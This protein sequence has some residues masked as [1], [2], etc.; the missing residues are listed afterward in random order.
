M[1]NFLKYTLATIVGILVLNILGLIIFFI[2]A[3]AISSPDVPIVKDHSVL[4]SKFNTPVID[5]ADENP[6][7]QF[8]SGNF[9][10]D[11][12]MGLDQILKDIK[13]AKTD[14]KISGI[15]LRLSAFP[16]SLGTLE[17]IRDA[18]VDFKDSGKFILAHADAYSMKTYYLASAADKIYMTPTGEMDFKGLQS[19]VLLFK[20]ALDK[21][22]VDIQVIRHGTFKSAVEP[23]LT[24]KIS[25]ANREQLE[26]MLHSLWGKMIDEISAARGISADELNQYAD[27]LS[28]AFD[29]QALE[30]NM[31]DGLKY[32]DEVLDE[33]R[34]LTDTDED[35][36]VPSISLKKYADVPV[37]KDKQATSNRIAVI[38]AMGSVV[39]GDAEEGMIGSDRIAKAIRKAREDKKVKAI[40]FRVNSGGGSALASEIIHREI[41]LA[42]EVKPVV[43]SLGDVAASGGYYIVCP[44]DTIV[45][46]ETTITGSIGVFGIIPNLQEILNDKIGITTGT[47]T[48][49]KH[50]DLGSP[51]RPMT[52]DEKK[53]MQ[54]YVDDVYVTFANHVAEGRSMTYEQVDEIGGGRVWSGVNAKELG[55]IDEFGGLE[56][57]IGIAAEMAGVENY[58]VWSLPTLDDPLTAI[59]KQLTGEVKA[60]IISKELKASY[61]LYKKTEEISKMHGIQ[62][63]MPYTLDIH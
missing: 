22:G 16:G 63:I 13:K 44:A 8:S 59:M 7:S 1:K 37:T 10:M 53:I 51:F 40:V 34:E 50:A 28:L 54:Q 58:R 31:I 17:E 35:D 60:R 46:N 14:E 47:V 39:T 38:Y 57:A 45:A 11:G 27:E 19:N 33:L 62:A 26:V 24:D 25:D 48:T 55:L 43:A 18:L 9:A 20:R 15:F 61:E 56:R 4:V 23:F 21:Y 36:D 6:F 42:A 41:K 52:A 5:R 3:G 30:K 29:H 49:N 12:V 2:V 32:Y